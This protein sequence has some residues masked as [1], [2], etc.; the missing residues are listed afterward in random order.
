MS[1]TDCGDHLST[2]IEIENIMSQ[3]DF[4]RKRRRSLTGVNDANA[5]HNDM[6]PL[7]IKDLSLS[8]SERARRPQSLGQAT[9]DQLTNSFDRGDVFE[10]WLRIIFHFLGLEIFI[11]RKS[12]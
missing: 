11:S 6:S 10:V 8:P 2:S 4:A 9:K 1:F 7:I 12:K 5:T 3:N